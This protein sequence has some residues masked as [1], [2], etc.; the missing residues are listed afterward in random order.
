[1]KF[2]QKFI[3]ERFE[4]D[5]GINDDIVR[6][7]EADQQLHRT[8]PNDIKDGPDAQAVY[9]ASSLSCAR[10]RGWTS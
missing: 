1:M 3:P 7:G 9:V 8:W 10:R 2:S 6:V 5:H 4:L